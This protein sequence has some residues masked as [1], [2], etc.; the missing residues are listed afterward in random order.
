M[1]GV[2]VITMLIPTG[3]WGISGD[4]FEGIQ[5]ISCVPITKAQFEQGKLD[6]PSYIA[7]QESA[8]AAAEQAITDAK[9]SRD[10]KLAKMGFTQAEIENW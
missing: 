4:D 7:D 1:T 6:Y 3:G 5:F 10:A 2:D 8:Q 9:A